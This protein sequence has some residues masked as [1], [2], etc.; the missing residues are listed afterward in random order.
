MMSGNGLYAQAP[1]Y[2]GGGMV[3]AS[4]FGSAG[5]GL[6]AAGGMMGGGLA[7]LLGGM[8]GNSGAPYEDA[9][10]QYQHYGNMAQNVQN[11]FLQAGQGAIGNYQH[12]LQ[13][14]Q[15]PSGFINNLMGQYQE[16]PYAKYEQQQ[17]MRT[18][19]NMGSASGM[20]GSTPLQLQAQQNASNISSQDMNQWLQNV[21][22]I[23]T[24]YGAGNQYLMGQGANSANALTN[25]YGQMGQ[26]MGD[27]A[28]NRKAAQNNDFMSMLM[29]GAQLGAGIAM[30]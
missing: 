26:Q 20:T 15:N 17:A 10:K 2:A 30:L 13:G 3:P 9:M 1:A 8:F 7:G 22:G 23:N 5:G 25:M 14:M 21:L 29:G 11:P 16:S 19:Q 12:W 27:A 4:N 18:A 6:G 28:G 24:Q